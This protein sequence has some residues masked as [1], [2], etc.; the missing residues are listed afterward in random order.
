MPKT[1]DFER[2]TL[3]MAKRAAELWPAIE[4]AQ[5]GYVVQRDETYV[6]EAPAELSDA[7]LATLTE[8]IEA[9]ETTTPE[10]QAALMRKL[11][12]RISALDRA[13]RRVHWS[14]VRRVLIS[15]KGEPMEIPVAVFHIGARQDAAIELLLPRNMAAT[16]EDSGPD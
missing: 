8:T 1:D 2:V 14:T 11:D 4:A 16:D 3:R 5:Y 9:W 13:G 12:V 10:G 6:P 15:S 7:F